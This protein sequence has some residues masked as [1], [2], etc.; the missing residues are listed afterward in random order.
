[1]HQRAVAQTRVEQRVDRGEVP[2]VRRA[3][4]AKYG[5]R[6]LVHEVIQSD[7]FLNK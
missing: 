2:I 1:V 6:S 3:A 4:P 5:I 7:L